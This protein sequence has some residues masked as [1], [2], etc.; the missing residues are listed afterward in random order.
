M[1]T[2]SL[3]N[4]QMR[5][6][7]FQAIADPTRRNII[8]LLAAEPLSLNHIARHFDISRPA[9]SK[10]VKILEECGVVKIEKKG[11]ERWC[12]VE[13]GQIKEIANWVMKYELYWMESL[14]RLR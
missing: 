5:R 13:F 7:P 8:E 3:K 10:H 12:R 4:Q 14:V 6:D 1:D 2:N 11:R 9:V